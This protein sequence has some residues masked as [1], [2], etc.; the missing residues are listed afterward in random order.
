MPSGPFCPPSPSF[1]ELVW[2]L[3]VSPQSSTTDRTST[4]YYGFTIVVAGGAHSHPALGFA[5]FIGLEHV[6]LM[7]ALVRLRQGL[8]V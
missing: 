2:N 7:P 6:P 4:L 8:T 1:T 5:M 3:I